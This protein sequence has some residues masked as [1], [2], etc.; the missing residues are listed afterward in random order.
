[1]KQSKFHFEY[2]HY[3]SFDEM[4]EADNKA[5]DLAMAT[6]EK[7]YSPYSKFRVAAVALFEDG[8]MLSAA[9]QESEVFPSGMCAERVLL[10]NVASNHTQSKI[11]TLYI[12]SDTTSTICSPC[13]A[14]RQVIQDVQKRQESPI[15]VVMCGLSEALVVDQSQWL[16]PFAFE[17]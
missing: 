8:E 7:S 10:Y 5:I 1:M 2:T 17:L 13:G 14:C 4:S 16:L 3:Q 12:Y 15:R 9:N 11:D 6:C